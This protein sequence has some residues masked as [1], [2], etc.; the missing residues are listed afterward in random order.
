MAG[1]YIHKRAQPLV[2]RIFQELN[3][4][5]IYSQ[6]RR[7]YKQVLLPYIK[8]LAMNRSLL[9]H[10]LPPWPIAYEAILSE[11]RAVQIKVI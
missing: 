5:A 8:S 7:L 2:H 11:N 3:L 9:L 1:L 6:H 10:G 4:L